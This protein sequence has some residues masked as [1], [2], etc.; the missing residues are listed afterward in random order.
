MPTKSVS[1]NGDKAHAVC[2]LVG[3]HWS[4]DKLDW[5]MAYGFYDIDLVREDGGWRI[6]KL[7]IE[8]LFSHGPGLFEKMAQQQTDNEEARRREV[9]K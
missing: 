2:R 7:S 6:S 9:L 5:E 4:F 8:I 3:G 1:I